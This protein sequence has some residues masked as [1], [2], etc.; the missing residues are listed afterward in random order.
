[1]M[2]PATEASIAIHCV[3]AQMRCIIRL[4]VRTPPL[5]N[6]FAIDAINPKANKRTDRLDASSKRYSIAVSS[7]SI[8]VNCFMIAPCYRTSD[9]ENRLILCIYPYW[10]VDNEC[11]QHRQHYVRARRVAKGVEYAERECCPYR[12][13]EYGVEDHRVEV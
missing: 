7:F 13:R 4:S 11:D 1:M 6:T 10:Y 12:C 3:Q 8:V 2:V 5:V 9:H